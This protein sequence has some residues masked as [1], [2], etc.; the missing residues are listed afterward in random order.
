MPESL[1]K[2]KLQAE[3]CNFIS[4]GNLA[5]MFICEFCEIS[6]N[7]CSYRTPPV[8]ALCYLLCAM[9]LKKELF[10]LKA[11][12]FSIFLTFW[13]LVIRL[14]MF[15]DFFSLDLLA[16]NLNNSKM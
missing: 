8:A 11:I 3:T 6:R 7:L 13:I 5:Q 14:F 16:H 10:S 15:M 9:S 2:I 12:S 1:F 4:K